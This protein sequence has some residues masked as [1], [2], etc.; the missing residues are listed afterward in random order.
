[1][2]LSYSYFL[3]V[4]L[5]LI[6]MFFFTLFNLLS[7]LIKVRISNI[8]HIIFIRSIMR[9][10]GKVKKLTKIYSQT[11]AILSSFAVIPVNGFLWLLC[12]TLNH[13]FLCLALLTNYSPLSCSI[14]S[15]IKIYFLAWNKKFRKIYAFKKW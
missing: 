12:G 4:L 10:T 7:Y 2:F 14:C 11:L 3:Y 1:M 6:K 15:S 9:N 8:F 13:F 5:F